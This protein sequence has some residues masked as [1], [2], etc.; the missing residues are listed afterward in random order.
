MHGNRFGGEATCCVYCIYIY[1]YTVCVFFVF[2]HTF[3]IF[4]CVCIALSQENWG[5]WK[6]FKPTPCSFPNLFLPTFQPPK[7]DMQ[8]LWMALIPR[9][10]DLG[11]QV[12]W[13]RIYICPVFSMPRFESI[14]KEWS[15][16]ESIFL[17]VQLYIYIHIYMPSVFHVQ[18]WINRKGMV[19]IWVNIPYNKGPISPCPSLALSCC[20]ATWFYQDGWSLSP[21]GHHFFVTSK[22]QQLR[23]AD[24]LLGEKLDCNK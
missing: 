18:V 16:F 9:L 7:Y 15:I 24:G 2:L 14:E 1:M 19:N 12:K 5:L 11:V 3:L 6:A 21:Q 8:N 10:Q 4:I 13:R 22:A 20:W 23:L 17:T